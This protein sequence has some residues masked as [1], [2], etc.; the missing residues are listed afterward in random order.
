MLFSET[1]FEDVSEQEKSLP[2]WSQEY[3]QLSPGPFQ[4][5]VATLQFPGFT[6]I[7][8]RM[9]A[10]V[11]QH[12]SAP[13]DSLIFFAQ[14]AESGGVRIDGRFFGGNTIGFGHHWRERLSVSAPMSDYLLAVV[15]LDDLPVD[16][17]IKT[18]ILQGPAAVQAE[19]LYQWLNSLL[20]VHMSDPAGLPK[21]LRS[22]LPDMIRDRLGLLQESCTPEEEPSTD[23][24]PSEF[25]IYREME[26]WLEEN[27]REAITV[28]DLARRLRRSS[29]TLRAAC[30]TVIGYRLD[31]VLLIRRLN[32]ARR[33]LI[34]ARGAPRR[35]SDVALDWGFFHWGRF[36]TRYHA[37]FGETPSQTMRVR[38]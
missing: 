16:A 5:R 9:N 20:E 27:A 28:T 22:L 33:D 35:V 37:L 12:Y 2:G 19:S 29:R 32:H 10:A 24:E 23:K 36:S 17:P 26:Q 38:N 34:A 11:E 30:Q 7:R 13:D 31:D 14:S 15:K 25:A 6:I 1:V 3:R 4:G 8:E 18:G 21:Q